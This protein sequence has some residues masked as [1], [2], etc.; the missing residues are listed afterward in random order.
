M[1]YNLKPRTRKENFLGLIAGNENAIEM[2]PVTRKE[3]ILANMAGAEYDVEPRTREEC[4][5]FDILENGGGTGPE[6]K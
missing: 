5:L 1:A 3:K 4:F 6:P 2:K